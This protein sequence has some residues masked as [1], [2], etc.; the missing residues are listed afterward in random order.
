MDDQP[1]YDAL[2]YTWKN[3]ISVYQDENEA[4][5]S[6]KLFQETREII[7]DDQRMEVTV[8]LHDALLAIRAIPA[9]DSYE[10]CGGNRRAEHIWIDAICINQNDVYERNA[11][12]MNMGQIYSRAQMTIIWLGRS[13]SFVRKASTVLA[14]LGNLSVDRASLMKDTTRI[15]RVRN[16]EAFGMPKIDDLQWLAL[17]A[18]LNRNWFKRLWVVQEV[19]LAPRAV[20]LCG[21]LMISWSGISVCC[22]ILER[23]KWYLDI[24]AMAHNYMEGTSITEVGT[25]H[26]RKLKQKYLHQIERHDRF[27]PV[28]AVL[29][30]S[31]TRAGLGI[32]DTVLK[33]SP[34]SSQLNMQ[35]LLDIFRDSSS[36][37]PRD[38][39]YGL[40][41][42][43]ETNIQAPS[44]V[45]KI[46]PNYELPVETVYLEAALF[47]MKTTN[48]LTF[49]GNVQD[50]SE[51]FYKSLPSW[52][53]DYSVACH[54]NSLSTTRVKDESKNFYGPFLFSATDGLEFTYRLLREPSP[55]LSLQGCLYDTIADVGDFDF[56]YDLYNILD[57]LAEIPHLYN[58]DILA[59]AD[60]ITAEHPEDKFELDFKQGNLVA[61]GDIRGR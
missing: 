52:V 35:S 53:P 49:L 28:R 31:N 19:A 36:T 26:D 1:Q 24:A 56:N 32:Q 41:G 11:Q 29:G 45:Q 61:V 5:E 6:V 18:F 15:L 57:L 20:A 43:L 39:V 54:L 25:I 10:K 13:D 47:Q 3:P 8:N 58:N 42:L 22:E 48:D 14:S 9:E 12:V 59:C 44:A 34:H 38:K 33:V 4:K 60:K 46:K 2:S 16:Y 50:T 40:L 37:D 23:S 55:A 17:Y 7:C 21:L 30:I 27:N 51:T